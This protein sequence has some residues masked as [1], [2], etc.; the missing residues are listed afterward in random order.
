[1]AYT[2]PKKVGGT[3]I[4]YCYDYAVPTTGSV[5]ISIDKKNQERKKK[6]ETNIYIGAIKGEKEMCRPNQRTKKEM[7]KHTYDPDPLLPLGSCSG[8]MDS[9]SFV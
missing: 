5:F 9:G 8:P 7:T 6:K 2:P 4:C 3:R 1:M